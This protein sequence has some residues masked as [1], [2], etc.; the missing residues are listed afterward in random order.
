V[1]GVQESTLGNDIRAVAQTHGIEVQT[2]FI[3]GGV[4]A[5]AFQFGYVPGPLEEKLHQD[6]L[7]DRYHA[8][9]DDLN[10][11]GDK[12]AAGKFNVAILQLIERVANDPAR[13][14]WNP[15]SFFRRFQ[16]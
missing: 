15:D 14:Q 2:S 13:P 10:Q 16:K 7:K 11:P 5:L 9:L 6:W 8:P 4:P 3:R 1:Q 12:A